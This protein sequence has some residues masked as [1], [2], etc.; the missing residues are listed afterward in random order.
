[1]GARFGMTLMMRMTFVNFDAPV[2]TTAPGR[3]PLPPCHASVTP[4]AYWKITVGSRWQ[5]RHAHRPAFSKQ[6]ALL[7]VSD[8]HMPRHLS[9]S[10]R[11]KQHTAL[12]HVQQNSKAL[13][14]DSSCDM[15][16]KARA[17]LVPSQRTKS[18]LHVYLQAVDLRQPSDVRS[19]SAV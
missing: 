15:S 6:H 17:T 2:A 9:A 19:H 13:L 5:P 10:S 14:S 18:C 11:D 3:H 4:C 7:G 12:T 16:T 8:M 1:M